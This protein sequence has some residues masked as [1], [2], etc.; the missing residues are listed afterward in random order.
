M[1]VLV[2]VL[3]VVCVCFFDGSG[4]A[5]C[6][7]RIDRSHITTTLAT[8]TITK[9]HF[10]FESVFDGKVNVEKL[11]FTNNKNNNNKTRFINF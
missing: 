2:L 4:N 11:I 5:S 10:F 8:T 6:P 3:V 7:V 1:V 9:Y